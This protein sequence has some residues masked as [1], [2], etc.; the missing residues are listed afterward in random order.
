MAVRI[1][2]VGS[3][4]PDLE[5]DRVAERIGA[6]I[7]RAGVVLVCGGLGGVMAAACRGA[8]ESGGVTI[9]LLPGDDPSAANPWVT[10]PI[11][12]GLGE[13]RNMLVVRAAD[14]LVAVGGEYGTLSEIAFALKI[15]RPVVGVA[16]WALQRP[17]GEG[18]TG[19]VRSDA[20]HAV[21]IALDMVEGVSSS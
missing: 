16:T 7:A 4:E 1:G 5:T 8:V 21:R 3:G 15:G 19:I 10:I 12:T 2:V 13:V 11:A 17:S 9:G 20:D 18:D 14:A 6:A